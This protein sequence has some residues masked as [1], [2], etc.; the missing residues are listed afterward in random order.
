[1]RTKKMN[2]Y[3]CDFCKKT[4]GSATHMKKHESRCTNNPNRVCGMCTE[5]IKQEQ[6]KLS[7]LVAILPNVK[8]FE[9]KEE[10]LVGNTYITMDQN[11]AKHATEKIMPALRDAAGNCPACILAAIR[12]SGLPIPIV[13]SFDFQKERLFLWADINEDNTIY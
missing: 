13:T 1:M 12:Q 3:W 5:M 4:G 2:R 9:C 10:G 7:E 11:A 6:P 8:Q